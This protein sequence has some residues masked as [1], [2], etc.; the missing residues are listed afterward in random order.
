MGINGLMPERCIA[1]LSVARVGCL[2]YRPPA[3]SPPAP[4]GPT[5]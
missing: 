1:R 3:R 5:G 2:S 4:T